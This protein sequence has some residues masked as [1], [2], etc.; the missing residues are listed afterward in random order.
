MRFLRFA[1]LLSSVAAEQAADGSG[2]V[3]PIDIDGGLDFP[4]IDND[5]GGGDDGGSS[6]PVMRKTLNVAKLEAGNLPITEVFTRA[7]LDAAATGAGCNNKPEWRSRLAA[8]HNLVAHTYI[9][10]LPRT[11]KV[12]A[13]TD[14]AERLLSVGWPEDRLSL[15]IGAD[16]KALWGQRLVNLA[17]KWHGGQTHDLAL[18]KLGLG[19]QF[20]STSE[21]NTY[22][23]C[24]FSKPYDSNVS[25]YGAT[26]PQSQLCFSA[27]CAMSHQLVMMH[28]FHYKH[29]SPN[30]KIMILEEDAS[31]APGA[32]APST[33]QLLRML[34]NQKDEWNMLK[35]GECEVFTDDERAFAEPTDRCSMPVTDPFHKINYQQI[36]SMSYDPSLEAVGGP[37]RADPRM[38]RSY[39]SHSYIISG[40]LAT[41]LVGTHYPIFSN[42]DDQ[43]RDAC[44]TSP[45]KES[46]CKR[47]DKYVFNQNQSSGSSL[48]SSCHPCNG[49]ET[50]DAAHMGKVQ[51]EQ[52]H[53]PR[54]SFH[55]LL[56]GARPAGPRGTPNTAE[57]K[58]AAA[59]W[60]PQD[61]NNMCGL[62]AHMQGNPD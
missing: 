19:G 32:F 2:V 62:Y 4:D 18:R 13:A 54:P 58:M 20:F 7:G 33:E 44:E 48:V 22:G 34:H 10:T 8:V 49:E 46:T 25:Q 59:T 24:D 39:C 36:T 40:S 37:D 60:Q 15:F 50:F 3:V 26:M 16:C 57:T 35:L 56:T 12:N 21:N 1:L 31:F 51:L 11:A 5:N 45:G 55:S 52:F 38:K 28:A 17:Q 9:L 14:A 61:V 6:A 42:C 27:C 53:E 23:K 29:H 43:M 47:L 30:A 41:H